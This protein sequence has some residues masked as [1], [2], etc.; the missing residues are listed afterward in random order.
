MALVQVRQSASNPWAQPHNWSSRTFIPLELVDYILRFVDKNK[1]LIACTLVSRQWCY[2][3]QSI[4]FHE[5]DVECDKEPG[6][7]R[8]LPRLAQFMK[9]P[10]TMTIHTRSLMITGEDLSPIE[11][12]H[13][14][15]H[16]VLVHLPRLR[17]LCLG[18]LDFSGCTADCRERPF[19]PTPISLAS[20]RVEIGFRQDW[21]VE[22]VNFLRLFGDVERFDAGLID[23]GLEGPMG[24]V[25]AGYELRLEKLQLPEHL[26]IQVL[27][28]GP[29]TSYN[30]LLPILALT[31]TAQSLDDLEMYF[32]QNQIYVDATGVLLQSAGRNLRSIHI[33]LWQ[34]QDDSEFV[35][36]TLET[37][38][39][40]G[41]LSRKSISIGITCTHRLVRT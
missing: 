10:Q 6:R 27:Q 11:L 34:W 4:L 8:L 3:A 2:L 1:D 41:F 26:A 22:T 23:G 24:P 14:V 29:V 40:V 5:V 39:Y 36:R 18:S 20:V 37:V 17:S 16:D 12:C 33:T 15:L 25:E 32:P 13:H 9:Q 35:F 31:R 21:L 19:D 7:S 30:P 38:S 28:T